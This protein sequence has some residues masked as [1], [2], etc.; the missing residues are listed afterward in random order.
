MFQ[1]NMMDRIE[2]MFYYT[3]NSGCTTA[4]TDQNCKNLAIVLEDKYTKPS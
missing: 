2:Q 3:N 1:N 4:V